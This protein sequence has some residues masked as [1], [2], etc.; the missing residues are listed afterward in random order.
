MKKLNRTIKMKPREVRGRTMRIVTKG[1]STT[2]YLTAE[3]IQSQRREAKV[4]A[5]ES[6]PEGDAVSNIQEQA[7]QTAEKIPYAAY[8]LTRAQIRFI[9]RRVEARRQKAETKKATSEKQ[10]AQQKK[11]D[12]DV[13]ASPQAEPKNDAPLDDPKNRP[14]S[15][16]EIAKGR[17]GRRKKRSADQSGNAPRKFSPA[18]EKKQLGDPPSFRPR[19]HE[20]NT[21]VQHQRPE[22][23]LP[24]IREPAAQINTASQ[25]VIERHTHQAVKTADA[26]TRTAAKQSAALAEKANARLLDRAARQAAQNAARAARHM[27]DLARQAALR[28]MEAL[29][30][31]AKMAIRAAAQAG[32]AL[33]AAIAAGGWVVVVSIIVLLMC[34]C[35]LSSPFGIFTHTDSNEFSDAT[36]LEKAI[37]II[38]AEYNAEINRL[39]G[40][41]PDAYVAIQGNLEG[42][43]EPTNWVDV[44]AVYSVHLTMR[45]DNAMDVVQLDTTKLD[46]LRKVFWDMNTLEVM[47]DVDDEGNTSYYIVGTSK[48]ALDM[49][50]VYRFSD[51]Q[52]QLLS[53]MASDEY[54]GFWSNFVSAS[55]GYGSSDWSGVTSIDPNYQPGMSG[56]IMKI[57]ALYQFDYKKVVCVIDGEKKSVSSSGCGATSMCMAIHYLTGNT[58]PT[59][60]T[61]FKWAYDNGHYSGNGLGHGAVSAMGELYGVTGKWIGKDGAKIIA[62]LNSG[63]PVIAHMG[64]GIFTKQGHYIVLKGVTDD[65]KILVNDPNSKSRTGKAYPLST[66]LKQA[67][68]SSPFM[69]CSPI[70]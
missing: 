2:T 46:E 60:Y 40:N 8:R 7:E 25:R 34:V 21:I 51:Q 20:E 62:A 70:K 23:A 26:A 11:P 67:K 36:S 28:T 55:M 35:I 3:Q 49:V 38:N 17:E 54:Y 32:Q 24:K 50:S 1:T 69:I 22:Q 58:A 56:N 66:I 68:T 43:T 44:L 52:K 41:H 45:E 4:R 19:I 57:R 48:S 6:K 39:A 18:G 15:E 16:R 53:E 13:K 27:A 65:G 5:E 33:V 47:R 30:W 12:G 9:K 14:L 37:T 29:R 31:S 42:E 63:H 59:P 64:P 10:P 61:L